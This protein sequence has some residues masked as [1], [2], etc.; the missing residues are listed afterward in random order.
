[1]QSGSEADE[2]EWF[3]TVRYLVDIKQDRLASSVPIVDDT[4]KHLGKLM[5]LTIRHLGDRS[6]IEMFVRWRNQ[7]LYGYRDQRP[8]TFESTSR[9]L[10]E[11]VWDPGRLAHLIHLG[12]KPIAR[13][14]AIKLRP[15]GHEADGLVRGERGGGFDFIF[16][17]QVAGTAWSFHR[18]GGREIVALILRSN[19]LAQEN[20]RRLGFD[21]EPRGRSPRWHDSNGRLTDRPPQAN[22]EPT[23]ELLTCIMRRER[24]IELHRESSTFQA[25]WEAD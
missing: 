2:R 6:L 15:T 10:E 25:G 7:N 24:F 4:G 9:W 18:L 12:D 8:V 16:R 19:D 3:D 14:G 21:M 17:S 23:D 5:P 11:V 22:A 1:M 20:A 13:C